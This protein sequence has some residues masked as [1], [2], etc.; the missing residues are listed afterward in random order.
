VSGRAFTVAYGENP[1]EADKVRAVFLM[2][3]DGYSTRQIAAELGIPERT[4]NRILSREEYTGSD[5][6]PAI[7]QRRAWTQARHA[8][9][10]RRKS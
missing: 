9:R 5:E 8:L 7:I 10:S 1:E 2:V 6:L 4:V 3:E